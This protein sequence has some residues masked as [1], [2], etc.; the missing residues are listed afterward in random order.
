MTIYRPAPASEIPELHIAR[1]TV[2]ELPN[3]DR[4]VVGTALG[5]GRVSSKIISYDK[6]TRTFTTASSGRKYILTGESV[7][8]IDAEYVWESWCYLYNITQSK[9]VSNEY[10][11]TE[12][13]P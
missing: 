6:V 1:W 7:L 4:H 2:R 3:R 8:N 5:E 10:E 9:D 12:E 11:S 13:R